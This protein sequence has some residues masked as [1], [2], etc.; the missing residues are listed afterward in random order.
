M[1]VAVMGGTG[2]VGRFTVQALASARHDPVVMARSTGVDV[3]TGEGLDE[4]L[5]GVEA[6]VDVTNSPAADAA[7]ARAFFGAA[8]ERLLAAEQRAGV[9]HHVLLSIAGVHRVEGNAH[10]AG[11]Q[12]QEELVQAG[13]VP[14]T[15][16]PATQFHEFAGMVVGWT[17]DGDTAVVPPLLMQPVAASDVGRV[18][19]EPPPAHQRAA[20]RIW[21]DRSSRISWTWL[22]A[23]WLRAEK[24]SVSCR[25]GA[26]ARSAPRWPVRCCCR[27]R[28]RGWRPPPSTNGWPASPELRPAAFGDAHLVIVLLCTGRSSAIQDGGSGGGAI[29]ASG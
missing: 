12:L 17:W 29:L 28:T 15:I 14:F 8:T 3:T 11:K 27:A 21:P 5:T 20:L 10:Y 16:V 7:G 24:S 18:L 22:G 13:P 19:A 25:A 23:R 9:R 4:A 1:R 26:T 6:V 2:P